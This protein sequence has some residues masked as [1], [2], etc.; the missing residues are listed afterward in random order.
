MSAKAQMEAML[1]EKEKDMDMSPMIDMVFLLLIFFI[2]VSTP[3]FLK[4]DPDVGPPVAYNAIDPEDKNGR[5]VLNVKYPKDEN[6]VKDTSSV[7]FTPLN[8]KKGALEGQNDIVRYL[9]KEK[10]AIEAMPMNYK[11]V[12]HLRCDKDVE[13]ANTRTALKAAAEA[14][15]SK[16]VFA[17][18]PFAKQHDS[19]LISK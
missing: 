7:V 17:V 9:N 1:N 2:V 12:L 16:V 3:K 18:Y 8:F 13:F 19:K 4:Q 14:G 11:P 10:E 6:G 5:I 15:I